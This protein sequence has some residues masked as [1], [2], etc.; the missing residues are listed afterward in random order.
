MAKHRD[1][2]GIRPEDC[3][4]FEI[5]KVQKMTIYG[6]Y[7]ESASAIEMFLRDN[8]PRN[9]DVFITNRSETG[10]MAFA[11]PKLE[12][13]IRFCVGGYEED[14]PLFLELS[15]QLQSANTAKSAVRIVEPAFVGHRPN[16][17][18]YIADAP[19][20][21]YRIRRIAQ[22][23]VINVVMQVT[24]DKSTTKNQI[25][26]RGILA[27]NLIQLLEMNGYIVKFRLF[28]TSM[29]YNEVFVCEVVL[30]DQ[31]EKI[32]PRKCFYPMCGRGFVRRVLLRIKESIPFEE[33]WHI[34]YGNVVDERAA[35]MLL[36]ISDSDIYIGTPREMGIQGQDMFE[37]ANSFLEKLGLDEQIRVPRY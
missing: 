25:L 9:T 11:G 37:D 22:K 17:P 6:M 36:N 12:D 1:K 15:R 27:L 21:M 5:K 23:K 35:R 33:N 16:V 31:S 8:P 10:D 28:E 32:E 18:A 3:R 2:P 4:F 26:Y 19:K 30:K 13:A 7:F 24:Y 34:S 29:V 14:Y 20:C